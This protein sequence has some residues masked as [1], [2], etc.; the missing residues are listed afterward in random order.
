MVV[1][2]KQEILLLSEVS[3]LYSVACT[4]D[5]AGILVSVDATT[6]KESLY[7][8]CRMM[9][10]LKLNTFEVKKYMDKARW[11]DACYSGFILGFFLHF[12]K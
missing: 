7:S 6:A 4:A 1:V 9:G 2:R 5:L 10:D 11:I 12:L 8:L 3:S